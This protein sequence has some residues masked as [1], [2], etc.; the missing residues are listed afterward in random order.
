VISLARWL[1]RVECSQSFL[2]FTLFF[3]GMTAFAMLVMSGL[4]LYETLIIDLHVNSLG[5]N[6]TR[7]PLLNIIT[8]CITFPAVF[9]CLALRRGLHAQRKLAQA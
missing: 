7:V 5:F 1:R 9:S 4:L 2:R 6:L 3:A 8:L